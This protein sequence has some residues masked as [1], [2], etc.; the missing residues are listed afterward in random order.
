VGEENNWELTLGKING[1]QMAGLTLSPTLFFPF[2]QKAKNL[3]LLIVRARSRLHTIHYD[4]QAY[5][6]KRFW[7]SNF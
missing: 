7:W 2:S 6:F 4:R 1:V 3:I 5:A